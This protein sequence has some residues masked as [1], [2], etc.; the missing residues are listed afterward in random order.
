MKAIPLL[1]LLPVLL[2]L[3]CGGSARQHLSRGNSFYAQQKYSDAE[4][5]YSKAIQQDPRLVEAYF[6]LGLTYAKEQRPA[7]AHRSLAKAVEFSPRDITFAV[8]LGDLTFAI[9]VQDPTRPKM[10]YDQTA[11]MAD[12]ILA[13]DANSPDGLRLK[14][15]LRLLDRKPEE[16]V[17]LYRRANEL[18]P[19]NGDIVLGY[20]QALMQAGKVAEA[21][22]LASV[23]LA[24]NSWFAPLYGVLY[25]EYMARGRREDAEKTL[26]AW[27]AK[28]PKSIDAVLRL[29]SHYV[30][31]QRMA[32]A[33]SVLRQAAEDTANF[34]D[35]RIRVGDFYAGLGRWSDAFEQYQKGLQSDSKNALKYRKKMA[36]AYLAQGNQQAAAQALD[37]IV[38]DFPEDSD[39]KGARA[40]LWLDM[41]KTDAAD[42]ALAEFQARTKAQPGD[43]SLLY[44]LGRAY[45]LKG[46]L[47]A[48]R[49]ALTRAAELKKEY[50]PPRFALA[51]LAL[52]QKL[53][54]QAIH[55]AEE[56]LEVAPGEPRARLMR[57]MGLM[58]ADRL[59]EAKQELRL[60]LRDYP[61]F[62][63]AQLQTGLLAIREKNF[64]EAEA[65]FRGLSAGGTRD[66]AAAEGLAGAYVAQGHY[67]KA[68]QVLQNEVEKN[69][70]NLGLA[71]A[72]ALTALEAKRYDLAITRWQM[73]V[74][75]RPK[76]LLPY[77]SLATSYRLSGNAAAARATLQRAQAID[78]SEPR[79]KGALAAELFANGM[80]V[81]SRET[82]RRMLGPQ[83]SAGELNNLAFLIVETG[84]DFKEAQQ[85]IERA[86]AQVP[87]DVH[88]LDTLGWIYV[89]KGM[90]D[91]AIQ[92]LTKLIQ[93]SPSEPSYLYHLGAALVQKGDKPKARSA[94]EAALAKNLEPSDAGNARKL[95]AA[96]N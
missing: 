94:L 51:Q 37:Q 70:D 84:G 77:V 38:K 75:A 29:A 74:A 91:E 10:M 27:A 46:D 79:E 56:I 58:S 47:P 82:L 6:R 39:A 20:T 1:L 24:K 32:D 55:A 21:E 96:L 89:K 95:L 87:G 13:L 15:S 81:E 86:L 16:S 23:F 5:N 85:L 31:V 41:G 44:E 50:L 9:Y 34:P 2:L 35:G 42:S 62:S 78:S 49:S 61:R 7:D 11:I 67:D 19:S 83:S 45:L 60:L 88:A 68:L 52:N 65:I 54:N 14:G 22:S 36:S 43:P 72:L 28:N 30:R 3:A 17:V 18:R 57:A 93:K 48:A 8:A 66:G 63:E 69:P 25:D 4:I 80:A 64:G 76:S 92:I 53:S 12:R 26:Q 90:P 40:R 33:T 71:N 59:P 73:I